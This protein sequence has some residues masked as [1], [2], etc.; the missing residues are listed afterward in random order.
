MDPLNSQVISTPT[1]PQ[2]P[3]SR[4]H[5]K[6][7]ILILFV[8]TLLCLAGIYF[9]QLGLTKQPGAETEDKAPSAESAISN[10]NSGNLDQAISDSLK[11]IAKNNKDALALLSLATTY[12]QKGSLTFNEEEYAQKAIETA[13]KVLALK[14]D[15]SEINS[16]AYRIIGYSNE[17]MNKFDEARR[18]YDLAI[19]LNP[20]NSQ[21]YSNKGHSY[22][23]QGD[24]KSADLWY[25]KALAVDPNNE[26]ALLNKGRV[27]VRLGKSEEAITI[28]DKL[29]SLSSNSRILASAFQ[30]KATVYTY[31]LKESNYKLALESVNQS[32]KHDATLPQAW[33]TRGMIGLYTLM[34]SQSDEEFQAKIRLIESDANKALSMNPNQSTAYYLLYMVAGVR[35]DIRAEVSMRQKALDTIDSDITLG[36]REKESLKQDLSVIIKVKK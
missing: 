29:T 30:L 23:L 33:V 2:I 3:P 32:L 6:T 20:K 35:G 5:L 7:I 8:I 21:A 18:N 19:K 26:H 17:I 15:N 16:E 14:L 12:A 24:L 22:D 1:P 25:D 36:A 10:F 34:D 4:N 31:Y 28:L 13:N 9:F 11:L 27:L